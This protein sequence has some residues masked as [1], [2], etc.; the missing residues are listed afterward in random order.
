MKRNRFTHFITVI[1]SAAVEA[2]NSVIG[3]W[4]EL[5]LADG[6]KSKRF[7]YCR[8]GT[9]QQTLPGGEVIQQVVDREAVEAMISNFGKFGGMAS[10]ARGIPT[11]EGHADDPDWLEKN[12]GHKASAVGRIKAIHAGAEGMEVEA[13]YNSDGVRL[14][15]GE[16]PAYTGHSPRWG[17][18]EI[19]GQPGFYRPV[20][21]I[22]D[23][24]TNNPNIQDSH[25]SLNSQPS[26]KDKPEKQTTTMQ[27]T[28]DALKALGFAPDA[29]PTEAEISAAIIKLL[30]L[31]ETAENDKVTAEGERTTA[32]TEL[33]TANSRINSLEEHLNLAAGLQVDGAV[34][35]GRITEADKPAW[36]EALNTSYGTEIVKLG[37]LRPVINTKSQLHIDP[38]RRDQV[39]AEGTVTAINDA[40]RAYA[41]EKNIDVSTNA[42]WQ[43][44]FNA[45]EAAKPELFTNQ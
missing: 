21:L 17:L 40:V 10:F 2:I 3:V 34:A 33:T 27:L 6:E 38:S 5:S 28:P 20:M 14:L 11:Y 31:K 18:N 25:I 24:L 37:K 39:P 42:G 9:Y 4:S 29:T 7:L 26:P 36:I 32:K 41:K 1:N 13:V 12:P 23:A 30:G 43:Q 8:Y 22:S 35:D 45:L 16:A 19:P 15:S 44:A